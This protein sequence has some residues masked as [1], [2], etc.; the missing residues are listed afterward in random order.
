MKAAARNLEFEKAALLRNRIAGLRRHLDETLESSSS[1]SP[2]ATE[3]QQGTRALEGLPPIKYSQTED[4][5][6]EPQETRPERRERKLKKK[7][8]NIP[9]HGKSLAKIYRDTVLKRAKRK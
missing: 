7:R 4:M 8:E 5:N 2:S 3:K 6:D 9:Q 1:L